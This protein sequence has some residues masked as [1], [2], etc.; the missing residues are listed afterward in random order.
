MNLRERQV[1]VRMANSLDYLKNVAQPQNPADIQRH[2]QTSR[3]A[4]DMASAIAFALWC[5]IDGDIEG[6]SSDLEYAEDLIAQD[7]ARRL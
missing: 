1:L 3:L 7:K 4:R 2:V 5:L 6:P